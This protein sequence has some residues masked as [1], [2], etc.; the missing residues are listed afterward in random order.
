MER[1]LVNNGVVLP[2]WTLDLYH[3]ETDTTSLQSKLEHKD[4]LPWEVK[5][6][7]RGSW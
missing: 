3:I 2:G 1:E 7:Q 5:P 4:S 6:T